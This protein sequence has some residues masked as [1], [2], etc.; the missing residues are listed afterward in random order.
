VRRQLEN[1]AEEGEIIKEGEKR[2]TKYFIDE[3]V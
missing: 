3:F 1:L 2:G